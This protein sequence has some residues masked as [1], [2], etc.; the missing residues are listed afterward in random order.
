MRDKVEAEKAADSNKQIDELRRRLRELEDE[1]D[2]IKSQRNHLVT[3]NE[4][5][6]LNS[7]TFHYNGELNQNRNT[8]I[9]T[10]RT[11]RSLD[12]LTDGN[13]Y[14]RPVKPE[15]EIP[16]RDVVSLN[17]SLPLHYRGSTSLDQLE[18]NSDSR[19]LEEHK[20]ISEPDMDY[21][22]RSTRIVT[23]PSLEPEKNPLDNSFGQNSVNSSS[24]MLRGEL[25]NEFG[26]KE[27]HLSVMISKGSETGKLFPT[28]ASVTSDRYSLVRGDKEQQWKAGRNAVRSSQGKVMV[29]F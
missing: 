12:S 5:A 1:K 11:R 18:R 7:S 14:A 10:T 8:R 22:M 28:A 6:S 24:P 15:V 27:S 25:S 21:G 17:T 9:T 13:F 26:S 2:L 3:L 16:C 20:R 4:G 23:N 29:A 19:D